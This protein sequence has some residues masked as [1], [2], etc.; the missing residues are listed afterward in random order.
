MPGSRE[1]M[2]SRTSGDFLNEAGQ[3]HQPDELEYILEFIF[4][5]GLENGHIDKVQKLQWFE[6]VVCNVLEDHIEPFLRIEGD[7]RVANEADDGSRKDELA[8]AL[9]YEQCSDLLPGPIQGEPEP[10]ECRNDFGEMIFVIDDDIS[11]RVILLVKGQGIPS[12]S[13]GLRKIIFDLV[14]GS[15]CDEEVDREREVV[16]EEGDGLQDITLALFVFELVEAIDDDDARE[17][18]LELGLDG[19]ERVN[20]KASRLDLHRFGEDKRVRPEHFFDK[21]A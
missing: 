8:G 12:F 6:F 7:R 17:R 10:R 4:G 21:G 5:Y 16:N 18:V 20:D 11:I 3:Q 15:A 1:R 14:F 9:R 19:G 13:H 2:A